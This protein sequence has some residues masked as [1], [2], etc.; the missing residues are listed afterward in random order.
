MM[1]NDWML[2]LASHYQKTRAF[3]PE[4]PLMILFDIDGTI[5]DMRYMVRRVLRAFDKEH[6]TRLFRRLQIS[7]I[8]VHEN[9]LYRLLMGLQIPANKQSLILDWYN[10]HRWSAEHILHSHTPFGGV[11]EV[12]RTGKRDYA[13]LL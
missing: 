4:D 11:L 6:N 13:Y 9:Q 3:H 1:K 12:I 7:D 2:E 8:T 5:L 10:E